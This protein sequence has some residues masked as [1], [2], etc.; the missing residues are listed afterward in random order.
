MAQS[1]CGGSV[2]VDTGFGA[3][4]STTVSSPAFGF[5]AETPGG[6]GTPAKRRSNTAANAAP[7]AAAMGSP[8]TLSGARCSTTGQFGSRSRR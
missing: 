7:A 3:N 2:A 5:G 6:S 8:C 4:G 1:G